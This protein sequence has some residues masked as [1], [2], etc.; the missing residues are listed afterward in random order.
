V[1]GRKFDAQVVLTPK[2]SPRGQIMQNYILVRIVSMAGI[3]IGLFD[4]DRHNS[5]YFFVLNADEQI[6]LR[7]GGRDAE[8]SGT[9]HDL[10]SI[11]LAMRAGLQQHELYKAGKLAKQPRPA[12]RFPQESPS[13][14]KE[15]IE[16]NRCVEC[17]L[18]GDY[19]A[20]DQEQAGTLDKIKTMYPSPD[21][22]T[23]GIHLDVPKGLLVGKVEGAAAQ[24]G[25]Q[26]GDLI[27]AFQQTPVLT[28]GDLQYVY[29]KLD[30]NARQINLTVERAGQPK[31]LT[32][33]L[34]LEWWYT[35]TSYRF[36]TIEPMVYFTSQPLAKEQKRQFKFKPDG[37]ASTITEVD[38][39]GASL[40]LHRLQKGDVIYAVNDVEASKLTRN[41]ELYIKLTT[42]AGDSLKLKLL[43]DGQPMEMTVKTYRQYFRKQRTE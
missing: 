20:Q 13:L 12:P 30:R 26:A 27:T 43:R 19:G 23:L 38:P 1:N 17:H 21:L 15:V 6:Y 16:R 22:K 32:V 24:A 29:G 41:V 28:F 40:K 35:D 11:E 31:T 9:Y 34:P 39:L 42:R 8:D 25:M 33:K 3:D 7:Y 18:I 10:N 36:W 4:Y 2:N 14:K 5:I 37:F